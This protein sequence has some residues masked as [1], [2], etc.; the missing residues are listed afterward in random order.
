MES[1][2]YK[3]GDIITAKITDS[4]CEFIYGKILAIYDTRPDNI[5]TSYAVESDDSET[6]KKAY[7]H[8]YVDEQLYDIYKTKYGLFNGFTIFESAIGHHVIWV[9]EKDVVEKTYLNNEDRG[10]L[11]FL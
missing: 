7:R 1:T 4:D 5:N 10:G 11:K 9:Y 2:K 8:Q 3:I 6:S